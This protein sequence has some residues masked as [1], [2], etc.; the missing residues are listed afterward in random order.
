MSCHDVL[1]TCRRTAPSSPVNRHCGNVTFDAF[2]S[3]NEY[4]QM[5]FVTDR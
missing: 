4:S 1:Q 5:P 3:P 2:S